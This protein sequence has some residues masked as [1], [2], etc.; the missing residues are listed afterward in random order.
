MPSCTNFLHHKIM[1]REE[2]IKQCRYYKGEEECPFEVDSLQWYWDMERVYVTNDGKFD[3]ESDYY[4]RIGGKNFPGIP[5][6]LLMVMFTSWG[7][8]TYDFQQLLPSFYDIVAD[9][10]L[11]RT[12]TTTKMKYQS[13]NL[14]DGHLLLLSDNLSLFSI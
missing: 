2:L 9:Y 1:K 7:K 6:S 14:S 13:C 3:G 11:L 12:T 4:K 10:L 8:Q 5:F